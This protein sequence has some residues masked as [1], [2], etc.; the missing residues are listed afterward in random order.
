MTNL[1]DDLDGY[2]QTSGR[3][4]D[5]PM[6]KAHHEEVVKNL[7][8][9]FSL[10]SLFMTFPIADDGEPAAIFNAFEGQP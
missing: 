5:L 9:A 4:L 6:D 2:V 10:A 7:A 3:L 1:S 8:L